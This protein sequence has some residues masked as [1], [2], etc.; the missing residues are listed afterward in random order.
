[1]GS[2]A[3][4]K[5]CLSQ[6]SMMAVKASTSGEE[7]W[8]HA[9]HRCTTDYFLR[10]EGF[11]IRRGYLRWAGGT[12]EQW[13]LSVDVKKESNSVAGFVHPVVEVSWLKLLNNFQQFSCW[14]VFWNSKNSNKKQKCSVRG[15]LVELVNH[16]LR[17]LSNNN[18]VAFQKQTIFKILSNDKST[19]LVKT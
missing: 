8:L 17:W 6:V 13:G 3:G 5:R 16:V 19:R 18:S 2:M 10:K 7:A 15:A 14:V 11:S 4:L 9:W 1:M 12:I